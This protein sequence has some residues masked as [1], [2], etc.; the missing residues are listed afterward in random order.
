MENT[1]QHT[2]DAVLSLASTD[3]NFRQQLMA[4]PQ[5]ALKQAFGVD[6]PD[7]YKVRFIERD[8]GLDA[9]V[10]LPEFNSATGER[11]VSD[12]EL[13]VVNGGVASADVGSGPSGAPW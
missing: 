4:D 7:S 11:E 8:V 10:V 2:L 6:I 9:L 1:R 13:E 5:M 3:W 12:G